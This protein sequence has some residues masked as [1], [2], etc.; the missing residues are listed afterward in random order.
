MKRTFVMVDVE[1]N[2]PVPY[3]FSMIALGAVVVEPELNRTFYE[4]I[5]PINPRVYDPKAL[6]VAGFTHEE[7]LKFKPPLLV[8]AMFEEWLEK[9]ESPMFVADNNGFDW[10]FVNWYFY[11]YGKTKKNPFGFSSTNL[12]SLY[13]GCIHDFRRNFKHLRKTKHTHNALD[14]AIGN[15]E[16]MLTIMKIMGGDKMKE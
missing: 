8:M 15:A 5:S 11:H 10:Q 1:A 7:T 14:D 3:P 9:I 2:G 12:G 16:A 4:T 6:E 13:K